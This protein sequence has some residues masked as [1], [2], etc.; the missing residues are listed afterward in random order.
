VIVALILS[1]GIVSGVLLEQVLSAQ[2][3]FKLARLTARADKAQAQNG[4]LLLR[5]SR[6]SS[7]AR[8]ERYARTR[9]GMVDPA[10]TQYIAARVRA[11]QSQSI[12]RAPA[13]DSAPSGPAVAAPVPGGSS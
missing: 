9:L 1:A 11:R 7:P 3:A 2:A 10:T 4:D 6:L 12:A 13:S 8:I 5:A